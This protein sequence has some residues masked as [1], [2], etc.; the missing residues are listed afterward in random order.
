MNDL[1]MPK[2]TPL[3]YSKAREVVATYAQENKA[4]IDLYD[5]S[6]GSFGNTITATDLLSLNALNAFVGVS[7]MTPM[8]LLWRKR[9]EVEPLIAAITTEGF[10]LLGEK[11]LSSVRK[12][13]IAA[14]KAV[15]QIDHWGGGGTR[16]AKL[17]HRLR[18]NVAP[19]WDVRVGTWYGGPEEKWDDFITNVH[20]DVL[21]N[22]DA[23]RSIRDDVVPDLHLLRVWDILLWSLDAPGV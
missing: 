17:L 22:I 13:T 6:R 12:S 15:E 9:Q 1:R 8:D 2:G 3:D 5:R 10:E 16:A 23:L 7:P 11:A 21:G 14:L 18:P 19:I 20:N 4:A